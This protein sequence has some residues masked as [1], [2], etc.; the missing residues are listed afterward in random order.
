MTNLEV[1]KF[2]VGCNASYTEAQLYGMLILNDID[3]NGVYVSSNKC[4]L[5]GIAIG[6]IESQPDSGIKSIQEGGYS[7]TYNGT[8][9]SG[10]LS[11]IANQSG[12]DE[13]IGRYTDKPIIVDKSCLW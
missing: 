13:L 4:A 7:V 10:L 9:M 11:S 5:Y 3:P 2:I 8:Q 6:A 1:L 12:C